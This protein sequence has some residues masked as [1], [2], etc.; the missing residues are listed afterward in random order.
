[1]SRLGTRPINV[2]DLNPDF[3]VSG[4]LKY[5]LYPSGLAFPYIRKPL[6]GTLIP[7]LTG[8]FGQRNPFAFDVK[9]FEPEPNA[10][11]FQAGSPPIPQVYT[12]TA[13]LGL[14]TEIGFQRIAEHIKILT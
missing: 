2:K 14:L 9:Q 11:R 5:L 13:A 4:T 6:I 8:W 12:L 7:T 3:Y 1:L 10:R